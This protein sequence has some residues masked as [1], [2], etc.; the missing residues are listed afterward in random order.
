[1]LQWK[2]DQF[3]RIAPR[4]DWDSVCPL[5]HQ[6]SHSCDSCDHSSRG[7]DFGDRHSGSVS[8]SNQSNFP[9]LLPSVGPLEDF[10]THVVC[11]PW[12]RVKVN[13]EVFWLEPLIK[14]RLSPLTFLLSVGQIVFPYIYITWNA[15]PLGCHDLFKCKFEWCLGLAATLQFVFLWIVKPSVICNSK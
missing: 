1:M 7:A 3:K 6:G 9:R 5:P 4:G 11:L 13:L 12:V 14:Q 10:G 15:W 2:I 8:P